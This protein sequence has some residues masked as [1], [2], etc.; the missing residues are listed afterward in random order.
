MLELNV[1]DLDSDVAP[2]RGLTER[3]PWTVDSG[4]SQS[5]ASRTSFPSAVVRESP[6]SK[7]GQTYKGPGSDVIK[8]EGEL[9]ALSVLEPGTKAKVCFQ[10]AEVR[11][12]LLAVS[13]LVDKGNMTVFDTDSFVIPAGAPE[14]PLIRQLIAQAQGKIPLYRERGIYKMRN[15]EVPK[16]KSEASGFTRPGKA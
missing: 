2:N 3:E 11:K 13:S 8:N 4:A 5:V 1:C 14:I 7:R 15:W 12:P 9:D 10:V 6:G 16:S